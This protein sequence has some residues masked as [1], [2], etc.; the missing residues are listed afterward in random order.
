MLGMAGLFKSADRY[1]RSASR[2]SCIE[3]KRTGG[4][5]LSMAIIRTDAKDKCQHLDYFAA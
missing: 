1:A 2:T 4:L 3:T 5:S